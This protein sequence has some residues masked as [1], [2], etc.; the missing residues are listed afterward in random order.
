M[1]KVTPM[2]IDEI[3]ANFAYLD[4]WEDKYRYVIELGR[5][6]EPM[7]EDGHGE[8]NRVHGCASQVWLQAFRARR[9]EAPVLTFLADSDAHIVKGL[10]YILLAIYS[11][12]SA[13]DI[14][15]IDA[16]V[17]FRRLG[18]DQHLTPQRANG[19]RAMVERI[20]SEARAALAA[21]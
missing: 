12:R 4:D 3:I 7:A 5:L 13:G 2:T 9:G 17:I 14:L 1:P 10:I 21:A 11:G 20:R 8:A 19:V 15:A 6:L 16:A 18:L